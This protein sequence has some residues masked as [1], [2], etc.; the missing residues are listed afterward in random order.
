M[1]AVELD[2]C[3][4]ES[5][6]ESRRC[7]K[8]FISHVMWRYCSV[9]DSTRLTFRGESGKEFPGLPGIVTRLL[10]RPGEIAN[11]VRPALVNFGEAKINIHLL[12]V[13]GMRLRALKLGS[14]ISRKLR[15]Y[16]CRE[17]L[18]KIPIAIASTSFINSWLLNYVIMI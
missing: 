14:S 2:G 6:W 15:K 11:F 16:P 5:R 17:C 4:T 7:T 12:A 10:R 9:R 18:Y 8:N 1:V 13:Q 3:R